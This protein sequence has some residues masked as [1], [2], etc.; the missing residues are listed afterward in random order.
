MS[1]NFIMNSGANHDR[2]RKWNEAPEEFDRR[3]AG[4]NVPVPDIFPGYF[5]NC[6]FDWIFLQHF[7]FAAGI[8][9]RSNG[10]NVNATVLYGSSK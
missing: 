2:R 3:A 1:A 4:L 10:A 8:R 6:R 5:P 7:P 9:S